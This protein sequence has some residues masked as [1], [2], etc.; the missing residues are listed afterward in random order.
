MTE[1]ALD[2]AVA[3]AVARAGDDPSSD[4]GVLDALFNS[5]LH[6]LLEEAPD[7]DALKPALMEIEAGPTA[8]AFD[9]AERLA[10]FSGDAAPYA[11]MPGRALA[12]LLA[13]RGLNLAVN[14][15][16]ARSELFY[17]PEA[18]EWAAGFLAE[19]LAEEDARIAALGPPKGAGQALLAALDGK[20]AA[21][22][23]TLEEAWL[24]GTDGALLLVLRLAA[25][26][27][28]R[29]A[30]RALGETARLAGAEGPPVDIAFAEAD[31]PL[32]T[33]AR[34]VGLGF[35]LPKP[36]VKPAPGMDPASPPKLR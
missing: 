21:M 28:E 13:G 35:E 1:T 22:A 31:S 11:A 26:G 8:L 36:K 30:A 19:G 33:R 27:D 24:A 14:P 2:R 9:R 4:G 34:A 18:L 29:A 15:G 5:E 10:A 17:G 32:L 25:A 20:L 7:A 12:T 6:L 23:A 16:V 3:H